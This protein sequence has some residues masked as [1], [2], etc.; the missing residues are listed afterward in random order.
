ML[1]FTIADK[2]TK[3]DYEAVVPTL[4]AKVQ[5]WGKVNVYL[6]IGDMDAMTL[7]ALGK[8]SSRTSST[9]VISTAPPW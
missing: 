9:S 7:P 8:S 1:S 2:L 5:R 6:E 3:A 4:N